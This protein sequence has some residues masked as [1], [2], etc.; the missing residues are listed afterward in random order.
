MSGFV[1]SIAVKFAASVKSKTIAVLLIGLVAIIQLNHGGDVKSTMGEIAGFI[2]L[3]AYL[4][5]LIS[6][7]NGETK[8]SKATWWIWSILE[9]M[10]S[11][12]Y[13]MSGAENTIW[14]PIAGIIGMTLTAFLSLFYG[15]KEWTIID[16]ICSLGS[17][18]G[19]VVWFFSGSPMVALFCFLVV[20][21]LAA[22]PTILKSWKEPF[23]EDLF[24][25][26][27]TLVSGVANLLAIEKWNFTIATLPIYNLVIYLAV[28]LALVFSRRK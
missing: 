28:V 17:V 22:I 8:P 11:A 27:I 23:E 4:P 20:D 3:V 7:V 6:I 19:I 9:V 2:N 21:I 13:I 15:K 12:S 24:A 16:S 25:W 1:T 26:L 14:L 18:M 5:Y 10:L